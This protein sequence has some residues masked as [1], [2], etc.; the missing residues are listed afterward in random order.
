MLIFFLEM[1]V[2]E[3]STNA[4]VMLGQRRRRWA[5]ITSA[6]YGKHKRIKTAIDVISTLMIHCRRA[7][8]WIGKYNKF[9][10][11]VPKYY[12]VSIKYLSQI[13][14][15]G[16]E[17]V[18]SSVGFEVSKKPNVYSPLTRKD[19]ILWVASVPEK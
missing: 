9:T 6:F 10:N 18:P 8:S 2:F 4:S 16:V 12:K 1:F 19:S 13:S 17:S 15:S 11:Y 5:S 3:R 7:S 14:T